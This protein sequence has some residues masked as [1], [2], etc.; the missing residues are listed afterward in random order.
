M[1]INPG[2][3]KAHTA[4]GEHASDVTQD[5][6]YFVEFGVGASGSATLKRRVGQGWVTVDAGY[7]ASMTV[8]EITEIPNYFVPSVFRWEVTVG[9]GTITTYLEAGKGLGDRNR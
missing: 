7:T 6:I 9:A 2:D 1:Q 8:A 3:S 5:V 4:S